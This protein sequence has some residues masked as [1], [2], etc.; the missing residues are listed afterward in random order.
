MIMVDKIYLM[1]HGRTESNEKKIYAGWSDEVLNESGIRDVM[2]SGEKLGDYGIER[3]YSS[4]IERALQTAI[5][6]NQK[7]NKM[8]IVEEDF[9]EMKLGPWEGLSEEEVMNKYPDEWKTWN[10][11]P[12]TLNMTGRENLKRLQ[13]RALR[14]I[15]K[16]VNSSGDA[17]LIVTHVALIRVLWIYYNKL[18]LDDYRNIPVPNAG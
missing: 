16:I 2:N 17:V 8:V 11:R 4:P 13:E 3:I 12:S 7:L 5:I 14:G 9:K 1:R 15:K 10:T 18:S 6:I